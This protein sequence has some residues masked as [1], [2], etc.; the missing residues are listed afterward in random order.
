MREERIEGFYWCRQMKLGWIVC[1][2]RD[3]CW[4]IP[5]FNANMIWT[6]GAFTEIDER[7]VVR[8]EGEKE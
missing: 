8:E 4:E 1:W 5:S 3:G 7:P 6:D 2:W